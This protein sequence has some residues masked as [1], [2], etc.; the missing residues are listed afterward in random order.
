MP[1]SAQIYFSSE[2][3]EPLIHSFNKYLLGM[4]Q[5]PTIADTCDVS[6]NREDPYPFRA[7]FL[8]GEQ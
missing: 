4:Y 8:A 5:V 2:I 7:Y 3:W 6:M 1:R